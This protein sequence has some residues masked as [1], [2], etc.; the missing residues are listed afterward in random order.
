MKILIIA[1]TSIPI[2]CPGYGGTQRDCFNLAKAFCALGHEVCLTGPKG[3]KQNLYGILETQLKPIRKPSLKNIFK[4]L[5]EI[6]EKCPF[7]P[8][9]IHNHCT[10]E[11]DIANIFPDTPIISTIHASEKAKIPKIGK[12]IFVSNFSR[13]HYGMPT[14]DFIYN[15]IE[16]EKFQFSEKKQDYLVFISKLNWPIKGTEEAI[17]IAKKT[18]HLLLMC[19]PDLTIK[20]WLKSLTY[21]WKKRQIKFMGSISGREKSD[22]LRNAKALISPSLL[23]ESFGRAPVEANACGTPAIVLN[24]GALSEVVS[25]NKTGYVCETIDEMCEALNKTHLINPHTCRA[26]VET[27]YNPQKIAAEHIKLFETYI[28]KQ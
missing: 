20:L 8:D 5:S 12:V 13:L 1:P 26:H 18:G 2:P 22:I 10:L 21:P 24:S 4:Y 19:G 7:T 17:K 25:H 28:N 23:K 11:E 15:P 16:L 9:I 27:H 14:A 6:K 3:S